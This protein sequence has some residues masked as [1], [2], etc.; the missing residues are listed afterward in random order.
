MSK[1]GQEYV[2]RTD[3]AQFTMY[4][5]MRAMGIPLTEEQEKFQ[6]YLELKYPPAK[7]YPEVLAEDYGSGGD[8][9]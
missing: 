2:A 5:V 4:A 9:E 8:S 1:F 7:T 3:G 6:R